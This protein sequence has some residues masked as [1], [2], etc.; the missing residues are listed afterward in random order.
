MQHYLENHTSD[1]IVIGTTGEESI[2][3]FFSGNH[4]EQLIEHVDVPVLSLKSQQFHRIE[5]IVLALDL[6]EETYTPRVFHL[7]KNILEPL[8]AR[9]HIVDITKTKNDHHLLQTLNEYAREAGLTNF[10][11]DVIEDSKPLDALLDYANGTN[12]G[13]IVTLSNARG[14]INRL[15]QGSFAAKITKKT[16]IPILTIN[17]RLIE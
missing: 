11:V 3:E 8:D 1:L 5:D 9:L 16:A 10:L 6:E 2:Q 12:A 7:L 17:Q 15:V 13:L 4:T 14:G